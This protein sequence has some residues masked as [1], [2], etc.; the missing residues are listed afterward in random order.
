MLR[1]T[2]LRTFSSLAHH[3]LPAVQNEPFLN[4]APGS[5]ERANLKKVLTE[6]KSRVICFFLLV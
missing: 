2:G 4:Y 6:M 3:T 1:R 5:A